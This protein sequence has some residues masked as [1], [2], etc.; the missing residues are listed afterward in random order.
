M[1]ARAHVFY[2]TGRH[3]DG[4][5]WLDS[6]ITERGPQADHR[7]HFSWHAALHE[8]MIGDSDAVRRRY[9]E[10]LAPP[11]V[12]GSRLLIDS[13]S[14]LWRCRMTG[15][16]PEDLPVADVMATAPQGWLDQPPSGFAAMH[17]AVTL[18]AAADLVALD[19]LRRHAAAHS[20]AVFREV[21]APL[22]SALSAVV[23][24]DWG[25][26]LMILEALPSR[27][28]ALGG[29]AAQRDGVE[30][31]LVHSLAA[32]GRGEAATLLD[33]RL[34]RRPSPLDARRRAA[35]RA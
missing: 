25:T 23:D 20:D 27:L 11:H 35:L 6:W 9:F 14:M 10:Q 4:L 13:G 7:A 18:A 28:P 30:E 3:T 17:S 33:R 31:T 2:E 24:N 1:H 8:L 15:A 22:C 16:W 34:S 19:R 12:S 26:A 32:A 5:S 29:S 21:V